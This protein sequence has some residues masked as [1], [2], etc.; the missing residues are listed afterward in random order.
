MT[1]TKN[2]PLKNKKGFL[3]SIHLIRGIAAL[4]VLIDHTFGWIDLGSISIFIKPFDGHGQL[5]VTAFFVISGFILPYSMYPIYRLRHYPTFIIKRLIRLD[6]VYLSALLFSI[7]ISFVKAQFATRGEPWNLSFGGI[8]AHMLYMVPFTKYKWMNEVFWTLGIEFQFYVVLGLAFPLLK[9]LI[10]KHKKTWLYLII[11]T[12]SVISIFIGDEGTKLGFV[13]C[14]YV[15]LFMIGLVGFL[16]YINFCDRIAFITL[17]LL[18]F[19]IY[20]FSPMG[21][22]EKSLVAL[23]T[24]LLIVLWKA[25]LIKVRFFGTIS[26]SLYVIHYPIT[27]LINGNIGKKLVAESDFWAAI[28]WIFP[29]S[30]LIISLSASFLLYRLVELPSMNLAKRIQYPD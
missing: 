17:L 16:Y 9:L 8:L 14:S 6:P 30:S 22:L 11:I 2:N 26:Y 29:L 20:I 13:I 18:L 1:E 24:I 21:S 3:E 23:L 7:V 25:P 15:P 28:P 5:A 27:S 10:D 4:L 19:N 12:L